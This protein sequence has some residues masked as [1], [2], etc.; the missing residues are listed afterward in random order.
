MLSPNTD[1]APWVPSGGSGDADMCADLRH[2]SGVLKPLASRAARFCTLV[3]SPWLILAGTDAAPQQDDR[4]N[5]LGLVGIVGKWTEEVGADG[6]VVTADGPANPWPPAAPDAA[7]IAARLFSRVDPAFVTNATAPGAFS[8]SV[9]EHVQPL[10]RGTYQAQFKLVS[11][12]GDQTA[13]L[14]FGLKPTG[15]YLF[16]RYN[17]KDGNVALWRYANGSR[18]RLADGERSRQLPLG[19]WH[20]L[21][22]TITGTRIVASAGPAADG[23]RLEHDLGSDATGRVGFWTKRD[24]VTMFR[25]IAVTFSKIAVTPAP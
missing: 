24:S 9:L 15:E 25:Q 19:G 6:Q 17:T 12:T 20:D 14:V 21:V 1:E 10:S 23:L 8:L 13:G 7:R 2:Y 4:K 16:A 11:G 5:K 22:V 3:L 18:E